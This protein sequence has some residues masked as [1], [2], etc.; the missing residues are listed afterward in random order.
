MDFFVKRKAKKKEK[1]SKE[2]R[3]GRRSKTRMKR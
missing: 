1:M 3:D 2:E